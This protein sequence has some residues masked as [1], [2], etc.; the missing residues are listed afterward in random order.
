MLLMDSAIC[1]QSW[2]VLNYLD[3]DVRDIF[4]SKLV[5]VLL[6]I[7]MMEMISTLL[8]LLP[9][10]SLLA[11]L[12]LCLLLYLFEHFSLF[13]L[14]LNL[15]N[16]ISVQLLQ[17]YECSLLQALNTTTNEYVEIILIDRWLDIVSHGKHRLC[18]FLKHFVLKI[19]DL[20]IL[21]FV[22]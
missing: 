20:R 10:L 9:H 4:E 16:K 6:M 5:L 17:K 19:F 1:V 13:K 12:I 11:F 2:R 15:R 14:V 3:Q 21:L 7:M 22:F 8:L 18:H